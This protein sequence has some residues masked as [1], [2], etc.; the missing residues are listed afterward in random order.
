MTTT[1][2]LL[3]LREGAGTN[4]EIIDVI[5][6]G[7]TVEVLSDPWYKVTA[8]GDTG[9][10][11][12]AFLDFSATPEPP[13]S[14]YVAKVLAL[15]GKMLGLWYHYGGNFTEPVFAN[16]RGDCSGFIGWTAEQNG[17]RPGSQPLYNY[18]ADQMFD[19]FRNGV[20]PAEK[21][22]PGGEQEGD[23]VFYGPASTN[24]GHVVL[25]IARGRIRGANH[26]NK[27]TKTDAQAKARG[28]KVSDEDLHFHGNPI[29]GI[30][31]PKYPR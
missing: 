25:V 8:N 3:N 24:A 30:Y 4:Y 27:L 26:G 2:A 28:A 10:V 16:K 17:Y 18:S 23:I 13:I 12:G 21:I 22:E 19:N 15:S 31:R 5:P 20:W 29:V 1:T 14:A 9:W 7:T 6:N 11:S